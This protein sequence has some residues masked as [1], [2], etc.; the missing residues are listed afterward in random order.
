MTEKVIIL[1]ALF[2]LIT[3]LYNRKRR[4]VAC[5]RHAHPADLMEW[6]DFD[7]RNESMKIFGIDFTSAPD[8]KKRITY[9]QCNLTGDDL[10]LE[11]LGALKSFIEFDA[12]LGQPGPWVGGM[13][14]PF[15]QPRKFIENAGWPETWEGMIRHISSMS[16]DEFIRVLES[17]CQGREKGDKHH[18]R[19]T[20]KLARSRSP[21][22]LYRVPVGKMFFEG[23]PRLWESGVSVQPC[24]VRDDPRTLVEAYP[25]LVARRWIGNRSYKTDTVRQQ[26]MAQRLAREEIIHGLRS[27]DVMMYF[28]FDVHFNDHVVDE[29]IQDGSG[30][31]LDAFL[32]AV[33]AGW[34][35][36]QRERNFGIPADCDLVE[37]WIVDPLLVKEA[38]L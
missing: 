14:F 17:Y 8:P 6:K 16:K 32:C 5:N 30:D 22:M 20:D 25:A 15:G 3:V 11:C 34:A 4:T 29:L 1:L 12:F 19:R 31:R 37:G 36:S 33:Q 35:F 38:T 24:R 23:A 26:T 28:G 7:P 13:D 2:E 10:S 27:K 9:A 18:L 21:M